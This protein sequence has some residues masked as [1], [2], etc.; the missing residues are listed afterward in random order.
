MVHIAGIEG[1]KW[2]M[3]VCMYTVSEKTCCRTF[4]DN[5]INC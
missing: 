2:G 1:D 4:Y 5:F 3:Y